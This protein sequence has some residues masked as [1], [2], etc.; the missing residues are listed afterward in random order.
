MLDPLY[1]EITSNHSAET[2]TNV[3]I[4][5]LSVQAVKAYN[6]LET[7]L[8]GSETPPSFYEV[9]SILRAFRSVSPHDW[10]DTREFVMLDFDT[11]DGATMAILGRYPKSLV[12]C[13]SVGKQVG[14]DL[15]FSRIMADGSSPHGVVS[16]CR[17]RNKRGIALAF[18]V[19]TDSRQ[20]T[21]ERLVGC[22]A[23]LATYG[24]L[25]MR[26]DNYASTLAM[27]IWVFLS[28]WFEN[29]TLYKPGTMSCVHRSAYVVCSDRYLQSQMKNASSLM[30]LK[31][32]IDNLEAER[33]RSI[34][35]IHSGVNNIS[36]CDIEKYRSI[37]MGTY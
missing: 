22:L 11:T 12:Y 18:C 31:K 27:D 14:N 32:S 21:L 5:T 30:H 3:S 26:V 28:N 2:N 37:Y 8:D 35:N 24:T 6:P 36:T 33:L 13:L 7:L 17:R 23:S 1:E 29:V 20:E 19:Q 4:D 34:S 9:L 16:L 25:C 10:I 15:D